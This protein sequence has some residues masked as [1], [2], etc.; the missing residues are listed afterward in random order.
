M[1][2]KYIGEAVY[3]TF[4]KQFDLNIQNVERFSIGEKYY[5]SSIDIVF[6]DRNKT[7]LVYCTKSLL[8]GIANILLFEEDPE[9][10][11][12]TDLNNELSNL[13][14]G[15]AKVLAASDNYAFTIKT[16]TFDGLNANPDATMYFTTQTGNL[17]IGLNDGR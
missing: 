5:T 12:I 9:E 2:E 4:N 11:C 7:I 14:V 10:E 17:I 15:H 13:I 16:P 3:D 8:V 1:L 6:K